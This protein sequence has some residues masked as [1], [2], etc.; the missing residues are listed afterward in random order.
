MD[1]YDY[2]VIG[3][4]VTGLSF[5]N[6]IEELGD[7]SVLLLEK[8]ASLGGYCRTVKQDGFVWDYSGHFFHFRHQDIERWLLAKMPEE[9][10]HRVNKRALIRVEGV[11]VDF[12]FQKNVHQLSKESCLRCLHDLYH[13]DPKRE[14]RTFK[15]MVRGKLGDSISDLF[16]IP[17]NEKLYACDLDLLDAE[18]MGRFFPST[19]FAET[20]ANSQRPDNRSYNSQFIYPEGGAVAFVNGLASGLKNTEVALDEAAI[21]IDE[22]SKSVRTE[23]RQISYGQLVSTMPLPSLLQQCGRNVGSYSWNRVLVFNLGFDSKGLEDVHWMYF[24]DKS[25]PFYRVGF[26]DNILGGDR[27]SLYVEIGL[28]SGVGA[29]DVPSHLD[30]VMVGLKREGIVT[31]QSLISQHSVVLDPAYVHMTMES[32]RTSATVRD[33]L[34]CQGIHSVGRYGRWTYC[35]IEDNIVESKQLANLLEA[36]REG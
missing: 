14:Y 21:A 19:N 27:M 16:L 22:S 24:P 8:E 23:K 32:E 11:D 33:E 13:A 3:G 31:S 5:A 15:E 9:V 7:A 10:I 29:L 25:L 4:G 6:W 12:P 17:Y 20:L 35:S 30:S 2:I 1:H 36:A 34:S 18:A 28:P 26:Y